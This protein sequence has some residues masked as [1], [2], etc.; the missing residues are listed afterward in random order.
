MRINGRQYKPSRSD[1]KAAEDRAR[2]AVYRIT[3]MFLGI[4]VLLAMFGC[5]G[6][7][8]NTSGPCYGEPITNGEPTTGADSCFREFT[9][10]TDARVIFKTSAPVEIYQDGE[11]LFFS[12]ESGDFWAEMS[13]GTYSVRFHM[14][15]EITLEWN[16]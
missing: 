16:H 9:L 5:S 12:D 4:G 3:A 11:L 1:W 7:T 6:G 2:L 14:P 10:D 13:S 15:Y 8:E